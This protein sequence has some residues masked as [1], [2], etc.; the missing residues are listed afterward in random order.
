MAGTRRAN[1]A[2]AGLAAVLFLLLPLASPAQISLSTAVALAEKSSPSVRAAVAT[3]RQA[4]AGVSQS[5]AVYI[6]NFSMGGS[7]GYAYGFPLGYPSLFT[8]TSDSLAFSFSQP[9]YIRAAQTALKSAQLHLRDTQQ[10]VALDVALDYVELNHDLSMI[11][12]LNQEKDAADQLTHIEQ[13][14]VLAGVDPRVAELQAELTGAQVDEKRVHYENDAD[15]MRQKLGNLTGLPSTGLATVSSSIPQAPDLAS[16]ASLGQQ[17]SKDN[18]AIAAAY[19]NAKSKFFTAFGDS[20]QNFRPMITFGAQYQLFE[21]F[22]NYD[23]YYKNF[24]YNNAAIGFQITLPIFD[25]AKRA[26]AR[27]SRAAAMRAEAEADRSR[28]Q[29]SEETRTMRDTVREL[30]AQQRV[31]EIQNELARQQLQTVEN[32]LGSGTGSPA[33]PAVTP[34]QAQQARIA[35]RER[36]EDLLDA[37]FALLKVQLNLL[38]VTG[39]IL[40]WVRS[41]LH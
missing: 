1:F 23:L 30:R 22:A 18:P 3:V 6:P 24:Q 38:R 20:R 14:R 19:A 32:E 15:E 4:Q 41:S 8:A 34:I 36:Y 10:Q 7:P 12:A 17:T 9:D 40:P 11:A 37:N 27:V 31:A 5:K 2:T 28:D 13:Q 35:D 33:S 26:A 16:A 25:A 39:Q 29:L 21:K